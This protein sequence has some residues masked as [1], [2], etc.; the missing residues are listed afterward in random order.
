[1]K[2][3]QP[4]FLPFMNSYDLYSDEPW[5]HIDPTTT[6]FTEYK[7]GDRV[8][9]Q[10]EGRIVSGSA[11]V[12]GGSEQGGTMVKLR[13]NNGYVAHRYMHELFPW[14]EGLEHGD[15]VPVPLYAVYE[16]KATHA[17]LRQ[18]ASRWL[19]SGPSEHP[20]MLAIERC[21]NL[22]VYPDFDRPH[23]DREG[24]YRKI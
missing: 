11:I 12:L 9:T 10:H 3:V 23:T 4:Y 8:G 14:R 19:P 15:R 2:S 24:I 16:I 17:R 21:L 6:R 18:L 20:G 22:P 1:M 5:L 13:F 7:I